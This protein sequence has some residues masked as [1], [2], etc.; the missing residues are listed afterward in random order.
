MGGKEVFGFSI[1][2]IAGIATAVAMAINVFSNFSGVI[3]LLTR[4][5]QLLLVPVAALFGSWGGFLVVAAITAAFIGLNAVVE[6]AFGSWNKL[7]AAAQVLGERILIFAGILGQNLGQAINNA[8]AGYQKAWAVITGAV[9]SFLTGLR[10][11]WEVA[12][13]F[14]PQPIKD[15]LNAIGAFISEWGPKLVSALAG[16]AG[17]AVV[18]FRDAIYAGIPGVKGALDALGNA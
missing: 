13:D 1:T 16:W 2:E 7:A 8:I 9:Q 12:W 14:M 10:I 4:G 17:A 5:V 11:L 3:A 6:R 15:A 18:A